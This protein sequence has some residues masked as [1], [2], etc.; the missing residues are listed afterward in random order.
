M[1]LCVITCVTSLS[2]LKRKSLVNATDIKV[3]DAEMYFTVFL[4][5]TALK[6]LSA[7]S[8][9]DYLQCKVGIQA[10]VL[11]TRN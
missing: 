11:H 7:S 6:E 4:S 9:K 5:E 2:I 1:I 3:D 8:R 10:L